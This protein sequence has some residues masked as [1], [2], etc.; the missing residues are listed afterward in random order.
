[1]TIAARSTHDLT[2]LHSK[3]LS[4][5][6][7]F[8]LLHILNENERNQNGDRLKKITSIIEEGKLRPLIDQKR[9]TFDEVSEAHQYLE[10]NKAIGKI[11][12][13]NYWD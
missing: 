3:A 10:A 11:V 1:M 13:V 12:L 9:F 4:F 8:M 7:V 6:V 2:P 5:H